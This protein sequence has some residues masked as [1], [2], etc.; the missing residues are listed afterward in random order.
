MSQKTNLNV[1]PYYDD[2]DADKN[3]YRVLFKPGFPV[4][5]RELTTLQSILQDQVEKFGSHIFKDGSVVIPGN[6]TYNPNYFAVKI[7]PT[8]VGLSVNLYLNQLVG[9]KI[10]G[11]ESQLEAVVEKVLTNVESNTN[12][13]TL[14]VK[15]TTSDSDFN[16]TQFRDAETL[17]MEENLTYGNTTI[18]AGDTFATTINQNATEIGSAASISKGVYFIRGHFVT[19]SEDTIVLDQYS[20]TPSYRIGLLVTESLIDAKADNDLYDN[21]RGFSNYAAPGADRLKIST[22]LTKKRLTDVD[23]K[24]FIEILRVN[25][26]VLKKVQDSNNYS[27]IKE[28]LAKRTFEE[29]GNYSID[30]FDVEVAESLN[31]GLTP[32]GVFSGT[33]KTDQGNDPSENLLSVK[34]SSGKAYVKGFD[35]E[36][37]VTTI[38]DVEK[39]RD[40]GS[41]SSVAIPFDMGNLLKV[42][43]I[44]GA[45]IVGLDNNYKIYLNSQRRNSTIVGTGTTIGEARV[46]SFGARDGAYENE[47]T[48]FDLYLYDV[49]TY[50]ELNLSATISSDVLPV[51]SYIKGVDSGASG[52]FARSVYDGETFL[53]AKDI[54]VSQ[55]SGTFIV[56]EEVTINGSKEHS[57]SLSG[58]RAYGAQDVK[59]VFQDSASTGLST[60]FVADSFLQRKIAKGF[61]NADTLSISATGVATCAGRNFAGIR[62][63]TIIS[64]QKT[65]DSLPTFNRVE[66]VSSDGLTLTL[67]NTTAVSNVCNATIPTETINVNFA[68]G[69]PVIQNESKAHLYAKLDDKNVSSVTLANSDLAIRKQVLNQSTSSTGTLS[70]TLGDVGISSAYFQPYNSERYTIVYD[71]GEVDDLSSDKVSLSANSTVVDFTGLNANE[72][73]VT[74]NVTL[75]KNSIRNKQKLYIRSKTTNINFT[76]SGIGTNISGLSTSSYYGTRVEDEEISLNVPDVAN[77]IGI[78]ESLD[79]T[80]VTL[81]TLTFPSGLNLDS[82]SVLGEK[83]VGSVSG[84]IGQVAQRTSGTEVGFVYLNSNVFIPGESVTF[85]ESNIVSS[86]VTVQIGRYVDKTQ[87]FILDRGQREQFYDYSRIIRKSGAAVPSRKLLVVFDYYKVPDND[88]GD[89]YT[90]N[91]YDEQRYKNDI[92]LLDDGTRVTDILDF[93]PRVPEFTGNSSSPFAFSSRSFAASGTAPSLVVA[94]DE[95]STVGYEYYLPRIDKVVLN[96]NGSFVLLKGTSARNPKEPTVIEDSMSIATLNLPAY[97]YNTDDVKITFVDNKRYTMRDIRELE[98]RIETVE[99]VTSLSLLEL[100]TKAFQVQDADGLSRFKSGFFVD[101]FKGNEFVDTESTDANVTIQLDDE[102]LISDF[103][104]YSLKAKVAPSQTINAD[105]LDYSTDFSLLDSNVKKT[106]NLVTL[107]YNEKEWTNIQQAFATKSEKVKP[108]GAA[109]Y[110]GNIKLTPSSDT[111]VRTIKA[112]KGVLYRTQ[113]SWQNSYID[114]ILDSYE[115]SNYLRSRNVEFRATGMKPSTNYYSFFDGNSNIDIIPKLL[116]VSMV[117]GTFSAGEIVSGYV[118]GKKEASFRIANLNH[119]TGAYDSPVTTYSSNPYSN[120]LTLGAYSSSSNV[121]NVDTFALA[122]ETE[123]RF[124]GYT[125]EG[126]RLV[127][128]TSGAQAT[129]SGQSLTTDSFGDLVGCFFIR[130]PLK[131]PTPTVLFK[132]GTK[133]FKLTSSSTNAS[134]STVSFSESS[135]FKSGIIDSKSYS[136]TITVQKIP[137]STALDPTSKNTISPLSQTFRVDSDGGYLT[138][139]DLFFKTKDSK[140][141]VYVEIRETDIGGTPKNKLIQ[142]YARAELYPSDIIESADGSAATKVTFESPIYLEPEKQYAIAI[143]CS[144]SATHELWI[145]ESNKATVKTQSYPN[146][147]QVIYSNQYVG[148]NLF[149]PQNGLVSTASLFEDLTFKM[150]RA[151]FVSEG[152]VYL[153]NPSISIGSTYANPDANLPILVDNPIRTLPREI[154]IGINTSSTLRNV[155][156]LGSKISRG[157]TYGYV[158]ELGGNVGVVTTAKVGIGYSNG[159]FESVP[160]F[161]ITGSGNGAT[162]TVTITSNEVTTVSIA[163]S[164][165]GYKAGDLLGITTSNITKGSG[166]IV[167]VSSVPN[168]DT[169]LLTNVFGE[170]IADNVEL[171][172]YEGDSAVAL[173]GTVTRGASSVPNDLLSGNVFEVDHYNHG[174]HQ[175]GNIV[176]VS[177]VSPNTPAES[178]QAQIIA[179]TSTISVANTSNF[180]TFEGKAVSGSNLGYALINEEVISY[181]GV[182]VN[183]LTI[184]DRGVNQ[185]IVKNHSVNDTVYKYELNGVSLTRIN[186]SHTVPSDIALKNVRDIDKYHLKFDRTA[187]SRSAGSDMLNFVNDSTLGGKNCRA[188]QNIQFNQLIPIVNTVVP[189]NTKISATVRT[190]SSTSSGGSEISFQDQGFEEVSLND[191]NDFNSTRMVCSRVNETNKITGLSRNKSLTLGIRMSR[192]SNNK[193]VSPV[194][195]LSE[196]AVFVLNRNRI[197]KPI[198]DFVHD[199]RSNRIIDDPHSTVYVSK[200]VSLLQPATSLKVLISAYRHSSNDFRVL[201]KLFRSDSTQIEQSYELF[202]GY[203]NLRDTDGDGYGD[204]VI[205]ASMND[206]SADSKVRSSIENEFLD[207]QF[208]ADNLEQFDGFVIKIVMNGTNEAYSP[209]FRDLRAIALA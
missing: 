163:N 59:S 33:Q 21:A 175:D 199:S 64:Y 138:A 51:G 119:K 145:A 72:S 53:A 168:T 187:A 182:G 82:E 190:V 153:Q 132:N 161:N 205:D 63:D 134:G 183:E 31:D 209:R 201:Y 197:N 193:F 156:S 87:D 159:T 38:L 75:K 50:T 135:F 70:V 176:N 179:S 155:V 20:N 62:S 191:T 15:Y 77:V 108:T 112:Q 142:N 127:G 131:T 101:N 171:S 9:K 139:I 181:S 61:S 104:S 76:S 84:A 58:V 208:T 47:S 116:K 1:S 126:M 194:I 34:V 27:L 120:T 149:K 42:N 92:A 180:T 29:S 106:G 164:G 79:A 56:G 188:T 204:T 133:S 203:S 206:G 60:A 198:T 86:I 55:T 69:V 172:Y 111:W 169:I 124:F 6:L 177:G 89:L 129:V 78:F 46:Y 2:F 107:N 66:S 100:D 74:V 83:I 136:D 94:P 91:S 65:G 167:E 165:N 189:D 109:D 23:D 160:L 68:L 8:H 137:T 39:P 114:N 166:A 40:V 85:E 130:N 110:N 195:D 22:K 80:D 93:R 113:S 154:K 102:E 18:S 97:L 152:T 196:A 81:D 96:K 7:N 207:Y 26:G 11:Q 115:K 141:K 122:D 14:F 16:S 144:A 4:Q 170:D 174:M 73:D 88:N 57:R 148:G 202:P 178:L 157:D 32:D 158:K 147:D 200:K 54:F 98:D 105:S 67:A 95:S 99:K 143:I 37:P 12:D 17:I 52:Y 3:F 118:N 151:E 184:Q 19:V 162:A 35:I 48:N 121:I 186:T 28:Y 10:K 71:D 24:N 44:S 146:A 43:N 30:P 125:P 185:S 140:E 25:G 192:N 173:A 90:A 36:K 45:P 5:S 41:V 49:Q 150:Y 117:S 123:G 128:E 103:S 13:Y